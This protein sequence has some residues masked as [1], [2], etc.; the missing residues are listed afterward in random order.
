MVNYYFRIIYNHLII[1]CNELGLSY[2]EGSIK[3]CD[4]DI[5]S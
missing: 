3:M 2:I 4:Y 1:D 5:N